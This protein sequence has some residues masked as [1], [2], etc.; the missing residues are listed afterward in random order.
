[1]RQLVTAVGILIAMF[2]GIL[3]GIALALT[4]PFAIGRY[5]PKIGRA[6]MDPRFGI[7]IEFTVRLWPIDWPS[8][9]GLFKIHQT[10][11]SK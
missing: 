4:A 7:E 6:A 10:M 11:R 2:A 9:Y 3:G 1:M 5:G 8:I